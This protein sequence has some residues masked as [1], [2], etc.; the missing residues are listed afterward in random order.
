MRSTTPR[1][2]EDLGVHRRLE[3]EDG[4]TRRHGG[5]RLIARIFSVWNAYGTRMESIWQFG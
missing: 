1:L 2:A 3:G 4:V 5:K